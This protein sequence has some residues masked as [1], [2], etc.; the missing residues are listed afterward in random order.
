MYGTN[1]SAPIVHNFFW[2]VGRR[3]SASISDGSM[4]MIPHRVLNIN[5]SWHIRMS[6]GNI[7]EARL[8]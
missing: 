7:K 8:T 4:C 6:L 5:T 2:I 1:I 3:P